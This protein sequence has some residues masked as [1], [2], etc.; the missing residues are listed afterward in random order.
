MAGA[1]RRRIAPW[2]PGPPPFEGPWPR[3]R[4][5]ERW[6]P[7]EWAGGQD[8]VIV[9]CDGIA[10]NV[11]DRYASKYARIWHRSQFVPSC[12]LVAMPDL[13]LLS[14]PPPL[15]SPLPLLPSSSSYHRQRLQGREG[16]R[17]PT[18]YGGVLR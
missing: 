15:S 14:P 4:E 2:L 10:G 11:A 16:S 7:R 6:G 18:R 13:V 1:Q 17:L 12:F 8:F 9:S 3:R 5:G